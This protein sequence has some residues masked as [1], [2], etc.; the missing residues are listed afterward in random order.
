M[1]T[2]IEKLHPRRFPNMSPKMAAIVGY[3]LDEEFTEPYIA[4]IL[5]TSDHFVLARHAN[6]IGFNDFLGHKSDLENN[7]QNLLKLTHDLTDEERAQ[8]QALYAEKIHE[9]QPL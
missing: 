5:I 1:K 7:W 4:D 3:I 2:L 6:D 8:A 9:L